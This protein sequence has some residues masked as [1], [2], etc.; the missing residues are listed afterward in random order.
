VVSVSI[1]LTRSGSQIGGMMKVKHVD[2]FTAR[3]RLRRALWETA[4]LLFF[5]PSPRLAHGWR[6]GVL[7]FFGARI[8]LGVAIYPSVH[9]WAPWNLTMD[10]GSSMGP[11]VECYCVNTVEI[12]MGATVSQF[13][14]LCTAGHDIRSPGFEL[15]SA[16]IRIGSYAWVAAGAF[17]GPSV[18]VGDGAVLGARAC[19][20]KDVQPWTVVVGNPAR[21]IGIRKIKRSVK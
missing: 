13:A 17:V 8:G 12:G 5:R 1:K 18:S 11:G 10:D 2:H 20:F 3:S 21:K 6:R 15:Q 9:I 14:T 7:Q 16:P 19:V 4:C